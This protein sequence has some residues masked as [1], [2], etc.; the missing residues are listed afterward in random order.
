MIEGKDDSR[1]RARSSGRARDVSG[2]SLGSR[3]A[4]LDWERIASGLDER[5]YA[6]TGS[7]LT[8][9]ECE[10]LIAIYDDREKFRSRIVMERL[11]YGLGEYK[12]FARPLPPL[13]ETMRALLYERLAP[14]ANRWS[15]AR[16]RSD[17]EFPSKLESFIDICHRHDQE[18]P[19]PLIL[20][21]ESGGYNCLHQDVYGEVAFPLQFTST[22]SKRGRDFDGGELLLV[23]Q[24]PRAQSRGTAI[25]L[26]QGEGIIFPNQFR[27][28]KGTRGF[29][30]VAVRHGVSTITR[31][32]RF[33]LGVI[34]HDAK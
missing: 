6:L 20:R 16:G 2:V 13:V 5:G 18:R 27:P 4:A 23:E 1:T 34:F 10:A 14:I 8:A 24:R 9:A 3:V 12:Y 28:V 32:R 21:Y 25:T 30:R 29:Y 7:I 33:S 22:L 15:S 31:G 26:D 11:N 17:S 19:T